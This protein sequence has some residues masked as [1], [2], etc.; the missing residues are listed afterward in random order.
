MMRAA[1]REGRDFAHEAD[2]RA[3]QREQ[4][5]GEDWDDQATQEE[6]DDYYAQ[7]RVMRRRRLGKP[8]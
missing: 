5:A 2:M 1:P 7:L 3:L 4:L 6:Q 8:S